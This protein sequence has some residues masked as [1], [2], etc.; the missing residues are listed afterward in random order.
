MFALNRASG[1]DPSSAL[2]AHSTLQ[3]VPCSPGAPITPKTHPEEHVEEEE[4]VFHQRADEGEVLP[5]GGRRPG[6][7]GHGPAAAAPGGLSPHG[8]RPTCALRAGRHELHHRRSLSGGGTAPRREVPA[9]CV[10]E[11]RGQGNGAATGAAGSR[12]SCRWQH[13]RR[14]LR[15]GRRTS[16]ARRAPRK[17]GPPSTAHW[18]VCP[19][20]T[21]HWSISDVT[22]Y[23][24]IP[25]FREAGETPVQ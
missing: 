15:C 6:S 19:N 3:G 18:L 1:N 24:T 4:Q 12:R 10:R 22:K 13:E 23:P 11:K 5:R 9:P 20:L 2:A 21:S 8:G 25:L 17:P 14:R 16:L 7:P